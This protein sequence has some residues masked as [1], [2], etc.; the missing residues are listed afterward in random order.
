MKQFNVD[1]TVQSSREKYFASV[2]PK[3]VVLSRHP[4]STKEGR[5]AI[6][7][8]V[9]RG[10][11]WTRQRRARRHRRAVFTVSDPSSAQDER[12]CCVRRRRVVLASVADAKPRGGIIGPTGTRYA[13][14]PRGDGGKKE[15]VT[16]ESAL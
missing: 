1:S 2:F 5:I 12:R 14:N 16:R 8:N 13:V 11:R 10:M 4:A 6:V 9:E 15:L 7:T 3:S